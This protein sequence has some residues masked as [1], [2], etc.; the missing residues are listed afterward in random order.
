MG[1]NF[2]ECS[3]NKSGRSIFDILCDLLNQ[4]EHLIFY[5]TSTYLKEEKFVDI[6]LERVLMFIQNG[7]FSAKRVLE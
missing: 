5:I 6:G 3:I 1:F 4:C 7:H 2:E